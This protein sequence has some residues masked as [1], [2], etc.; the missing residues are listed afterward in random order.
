MI[1]RSLACEASLDPRAFRRR[2]QVRFLLGSPVVLLFQ[3]CCSLEA[4][5]PHQ[6]RPSRSG[7]L[8]VGTLTMIVIQG[9]VN[10]AVRCQQ[11]V[12][13]FLFIGRAVVRHGGPA[14]FVS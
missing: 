6:M 9:I 5:D 11:I 14:T 4:T 12:E 2:Y 3:A 7:A 1:F 13:Q 8:L 10:L